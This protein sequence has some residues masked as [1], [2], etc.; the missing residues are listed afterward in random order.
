M[1]RTEMLEAQKTK[2]RNTVEIIN[3]DL[4]EKDKAL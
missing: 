2:Y 3:K 4:S 1:L